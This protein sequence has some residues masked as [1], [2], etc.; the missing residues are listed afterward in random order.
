MDFI[1]L[2]IISFAIAAPLVWYLVDL[3]LGNF[4]YKVEVDWSF[5]AIGFIST[6]C[7]V[8]LTIS[9]RS[10]RAAGLNPAVTLKSE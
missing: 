6:L 7:I 1:K 10:V 4:A 3:W 2:V 8:L 5:F 9:Y